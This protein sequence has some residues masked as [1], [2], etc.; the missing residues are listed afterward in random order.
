MIEKLVTVAT[1]STA[2]EADLAKYELEEQGI[3]C[4]L[5]DV[6]LVQMNWFLGNAVGFIKLQ[7]SSKDRDAAIEVLQSLPKRGPTKTSVIA[8]DSNSCL[9]CGAAMSDDAD[10][11]PACGWSFVS[12]G[13]NQE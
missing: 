3:R 5:A 6:N 7:V 11:C 9:S 10:S 8:N 1:Y 13:D 2:P 4:F 12:E